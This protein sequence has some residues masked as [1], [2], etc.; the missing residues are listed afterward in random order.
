MKYKQS[1]ILPDELLKAG[2]D[3]GAKLARLRK[4]RRILQ[5][6]AAA[7]AGLSRSTAVLLEKGDPGRSLGQILRY[8]DAIA[9]G[10]TL[11][12]LLQ[13]KDPALAAL[14]QAERTQRVRRLSDKELKE[15]DF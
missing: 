4:A 7:R 13:E 11:E 9:P 1:A 6:D 14:A 12:Q 5:A 8:L 3:L 15:L 10:A 2:E